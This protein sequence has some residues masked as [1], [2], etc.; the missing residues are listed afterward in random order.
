[1]EFLADLGLFAAKA[2]LVVLAIAFVIGA[3]AKA[4]RSG[5]EEAKGDL[6]VKRLD[7]RWRKTALAMQRALSSKKA[8]KAIAAAEAKR[9]KAEL[10]AA[11]R[12]KIYVLDFDGNLRA[13][14]VAGLA[15]EVN[16]ILLSSAKGDEVVVRLKSPGGLVHAYGLAASQLARLRD[17]GLEVT[18]VVDQVAASGGYMMAVVAQKIVA[19]P[20]AVI[21]SIGVVAGIPNL[22][23]WLKNHDVDYELLTA[24]KYKRTLTMLGENTPE[25]RQKFQEE[26]EQAHAL[27]KGHIARYRPGLDLETVATGEHWYGMQAL[28]FG[29]V[30]ALGT[31]DD[32][33]LAAR[34]RGDVFQV[35]WTPRRRL[36]D[37]VGGAVEGGLAKAVERVWER[38]EERRFP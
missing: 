19:A 13:T 35:Q 37:K 22:H 10:G 11:P 29:L 33:L 34:E 9:D 1:M 14:Q 38:S 4:G 18:A 36:L 5:G 32:Y 12:K 28:E 23:R 8:F 24:G 7:R 27:F 31:S 17:A 26:L 6:R 21:G 3:I 2:L 16:A 20:F 25:G 30:D 15:E